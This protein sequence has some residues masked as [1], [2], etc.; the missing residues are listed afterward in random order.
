MLVKLSKYD[1]KKVYKVLIIFY[2]LSIFFATLTRVLLN[3]NNSFVIGVIGQICSGVT[4]SMIFNILINNL[5]R[6]WI[7]FKNTL[8]DDESYLTH[9]LPVDRKTIYLSKIVVSMITMFT[10]ILVIVL[11]LFIAYYSKE[12]METLKN[13]LLPLANL[14]K[15]SILGVLVLF[16]AVF[17]IETLNI[18]QTGY[19]GIIL[20]HKMNS[21]R[22]AFSVGYGFLVYIITQVV[23]LFSAFIIS[24]FNKNLK[25]LFITNEAIDVD[26]VKILGILCISIYTIIFI[27][28]FFIN[29]KLLNKGVNVE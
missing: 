14:Y 8:Y 21:G 2:I 22:S 20:G 26:M 11:T 1:L 27:I 19:T 24:L 25:N 23:S 17:L 15:S 28:N 12:N 10:S 5:L 18:L 13:F 6:L 9:T 29:R 3:I 4:I 7:R 16:L